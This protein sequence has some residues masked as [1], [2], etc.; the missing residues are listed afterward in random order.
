MGRGRREDSDAHDVG[1]APA[2]V[3][4]DEYLI[5]VD[6]QNHAVERERTAVRILKP[7]GREYSHCSIGYDIDEKLN[8]FRSWTLLPTGASF[9]P[10][11]RTSRTRVPTPLP[12]CSSLSAFAR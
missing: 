4:F 11:T 8:Y 10:W 1:D 5:T 6:E 12:S 7:Q 3:L 9:R 2:V